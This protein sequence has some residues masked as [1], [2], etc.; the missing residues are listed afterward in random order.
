MMI[1]AGPKRIKRRRAK[2]G[3]VTIVARHK[4]QAIGHRGGREQA[5]DH[6]DRSNGAHA[7]PLVGNG[8]VDTE[9]APTEGGHY[10]AQPA[11]ERRC[12]AGI[13]GASK[14][15]ALPDLAENQRAQEEILVSNRRIP[16]GNLRVATI[17]LTNLGDDVGVYQ[18]AHR[19]PS[20]PRSRER[21][22][23]IPSSGADASSAFKPT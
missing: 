16:F 18:V 17:A 14:L 10:I 3:N 12:P 21:S 4:R 20:R 22:R 15:D 19:S 7:P 5:V 13:A 8:I 1:S 9:H 2:P 6:R 11:F 23:S